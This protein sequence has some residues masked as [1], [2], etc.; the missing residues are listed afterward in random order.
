V[1]EE[2]EDRPGV[3]TLSLATGFSTRSIPRLERHLGALVELAEAQDWPGE[4][5]PALEAEVARLLDAAKRWKAAAEEAVS[6]EEDR[7]T[8]RE[9]RLEELQERED[10]LDRYVT[11]LE[12]QELQ[13]ALDA[14]L[15]W[16]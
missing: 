4:E 2:E 7:A 13:E 10:V 16:T 12:N 8:P 14:I 3:P 6:N 15:E 5:F 11:A 9:E 1:E